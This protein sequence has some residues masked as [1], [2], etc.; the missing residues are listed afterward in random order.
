MKSGSRS[1]TATSRFRRRDGDGDGDG[2]VVGMQAPVTT[3]VTGTD[4]PWSFTPF[5]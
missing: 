1:I 5:L 3:V 2:G 4:F